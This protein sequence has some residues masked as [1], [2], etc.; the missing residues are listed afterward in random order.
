MGAFYRSQ[1]EFVFVLRNGP[2]QHLNNVELGK[3]GR[4]RSNI[5]QY[6]GCA[7]GGSEARRDLEAH[8]TP[9]PVV[10]VKDALLD[11][12]QRGDIVLDP[13]SGGGSTLIAAERTR[14][15]ARVMELD[16][17]YVNTAILRW[18]AVSGGIARHQA[19]GKTYSELQWAREHEAAASAPPPPRQRTRP[20]GRA[21]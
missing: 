10:L 9:K 11:C 20:A 19:T 18:E 1:H 7:A 16:P 13:F 2:T 14:R 5:W 8:P 4:N 21:A 3:H 6:R 15:R 17:G 12:T